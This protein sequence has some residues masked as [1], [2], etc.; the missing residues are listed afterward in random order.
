MRRVVLSVALIVAFV[1]LPVLREWPVARLHAASGLVQAAVASATGLTIST[2]PTTLSFG[3]NTTNGSTI[4]AALS[5]NHATLT[6]DIDDGTNNFTSAVQNDQPGA[7]GTATVWY[8]HAS[9]VIASVRFATT[10][11]SSS[12]CQVFAYEV[13]GLQN[14]VPQTGSSDGGAS[15]SQNCSSTGLTATGFAVCVAT[16]SAGQTYTAPSGY[17]KQ[18]TNGEI[19]GAFYTA[20]GTFS[21]HQGA[22]TQSSA[23]N[24]TGA[25]AIFPETAAAG[26]RGPQCLLLAQC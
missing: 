9:G 7:S 4:V 22:Y 6:L 20:Q 17:T 15:T 18:A 24:S 3:G 26:G 8:R 1:S 13:S 12:P 16:S 10:S 2:T 14:A 23:V 11:G 19:T 25:L 21:S 5:C